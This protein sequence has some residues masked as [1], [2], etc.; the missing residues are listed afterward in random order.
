M[1]NKQK[2]VELPHA[3]LASGEYS[4]HADLVTNFDYIE[5]KCTAGGEYAASLIEDYNTSREK[6][7]LGPKFQ[8]VRSFFRF[9][10]TW[11]LVLRRNPSCLTSLA[12]N[13]VPG[14]PVTVQMQCKWD[15]KLGVEDAGWIKWENAPKAIDPCVSTILIPR[16]GSI[17]A[18]RCHP[19]TGRCVVGGNRFCGVYDTRTHR[20]L[21]EF[22][23]HSS[24]IRGACFSMDGRYVLSVSND[25]TGRVWNSHSAEQCCVLSGH[26]GWVVDC[27]W[28]ATDDVV[29]TVSEDGTARLWNPYL[30]DLIAVQ[31]SHGTALKTGRLSPLR[32]EAI[33]GDVEGKVLK[34]SVP[35]CKILRSTEIGETVTCLQW[36]GPAQTIAAATIGGKIHILSEKL[37][38]QR[39]LDGMTL[40][41]LSMF[42]TVSVSAFYRFFLHSAQ[43]RLF[44]EWQGIGGSRCRARRPRV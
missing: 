20:L 5:A 13:Y 18:L 17:T 22:R 25:C 43:L 19:D 21:S 28:S 38:T 29:M 33:T 23:G 26:L 3:L 35:A 32:S 39:T 6:V 37:E 14:N 15:Q 31:E 27:D 42:E 12:L 16:A 4:D 30:G 7:H 40:H 36:N 1:P 9:I 44:A 24:W 2:L 11:F 10:G 41:S 34:W 8:H